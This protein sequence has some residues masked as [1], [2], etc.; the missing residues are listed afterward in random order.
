MASVGLSVD[1]ANVQGLVLQPY[2][3]KLARYILFEFGA[4]SPVKQFLG[5]LVPQITTGATP[6]D[7]SVPTLC[8][9]ALTYTG[10]SR[11]GQSAAFLSQLDPMLAEGPDPITLGDIP[12][13]PS[14]PATWWE[15]QFNTDRIDCMVQ[16]FGKDSTVLDESVAALAR[17][18]EQFE[19]RELVPGSRLGGQSIAGG[20]VHFGYRDGISQP[21]IGWNEA[22]LTPQ[23]LHFRHFL[24]G[25]ASPDVYSSPGSGP[26]AD[27]LR[28]S[29]YLVFRWVYQDVAA[30]NRY[31]RTQ[32]SV[33]APQLPAA[34]AR[35][36][37][38]AKLV[39]R[40]RDGT[41]LV[42]S[43]EGPSD[44]VP[45]NAG[46]AYQA[47]DPDGLKCPFSAH[48]RV[49][50]PRDQPLDA[51]QATQGVP[52]VIRR[53]IPYGPEMSD[54]STTD[55]GV[56]RGLMGVFICSNIRRQFYTLMRWISENSFSPVFSGN[57]HAQDPLFGNRGYQGAS[58]D[59]LVPTSTGGVKLSGLPQFIRTKGTAFFLLPS[60]AALRYLASENTK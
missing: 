21:D 49:C 44:S 12:G 40:W 10:M 28:D 43:P 38:A 8:N 11:L 53:G 2:R 18:A 33:L 57:R 25:Y 42:L 37:V 4:A 9:V 26:F 60:V 1:L 27:A 48:A 23:Q 46:F 30:F 5:A 51:V 47:Q 59:F 17:L 50:N 13:T 45:N 35:E 16:L 29:S 56:D 6:L 34:E 31:L 3:Y 20:K 7:G 15:G 55:D 14:D 58:S 19:V 39:G 24:L 36:L 32:A 22:S 41:P 54:D 52:R